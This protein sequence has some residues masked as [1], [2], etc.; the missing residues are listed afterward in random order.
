MSFADVTSRWYEARDRYFFGRFAQGPSMIDYITSLGP[1]RPK[2]T[3]E[4]QFW[5]DLDYQHAQVRDA[6]AV[7]R[8]EMRADE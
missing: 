1:P 3:P 8:G 6:Y 2:P 5:N 4:Q 7:L